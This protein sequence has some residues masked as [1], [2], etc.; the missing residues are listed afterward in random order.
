MGRYDQAVAPLRRA[1]AGPNA[2]W[3]HL[4]LAIAYTE[5]G[6]GSEARGEAGEVMRISPS[7]VLPSLEKAP[8]SAIP[9]LAGKDP[10]LQR[11]FDADL[12]KAG[13]K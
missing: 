10:V 12:R 6:R 13:L 8:Y 7:Y 1:I 2:L 4:A 5:L 3:F 9:F 11:R